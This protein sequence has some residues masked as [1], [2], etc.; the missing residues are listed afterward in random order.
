M[1]AIG[2]LPEYRV[3]VRVLPQ[4]GFAASI[5]ATE[6]E[7]AV[8]AAYCGIPK[9]ERLHADLVLRKWRSDGVSVNGRLHAAVEQQC[10]VSLEPVAQEIDVAI[11]RTF[12]PPG[13]RLA[14]PDAGGELVLDPLGDDAPDLFEGSEIDLWPVVAETLLLSLDPFPRA[15]GASLNPAYAPPGEAGEPGEAQT[16]SPFAVLAEKKPEG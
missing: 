15:P 12:L 8:L 7:L 9:V 1:T 13:S 14:K 6:D 16:A 5:D 4:A 11:D 10:V 3:H 2:E